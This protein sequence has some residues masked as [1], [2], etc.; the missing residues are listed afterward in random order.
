M[1]MAGLE[2]FRNSAEF[3][4]CRKDGNEGGMAE[5]EER[6]EKRGRGERH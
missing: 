6:D 4:I 3:M 2:W 1:G 5:E